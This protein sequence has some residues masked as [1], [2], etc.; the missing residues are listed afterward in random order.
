MR[1]ENVLKVYTGSKVTASLIKEKLENCGI[2]AFLNTGY[3][4]LLS[5][6]PE[7]ISQNTDV[8]VYKGDL[9]KAQQVVEEIYIDIMNT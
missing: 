5:E 4:K 3:Q 8:F 6:Q 7:K 2:S 9:A 1:K